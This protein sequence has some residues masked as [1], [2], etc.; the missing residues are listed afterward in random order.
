VHSATGRTKPADARLEVSRFTTAY[1]SL[2]ACSVRELRDE[3]LF[4]QDG[5]ARHGARIR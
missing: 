5:S 1:D 4:Q 3:D 2:V